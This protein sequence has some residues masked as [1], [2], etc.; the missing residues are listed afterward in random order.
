MWAWHYMWLWLQQYPNPCRLKKNMNRK[1]LLH[2][3]SC[4][5][6]LKTSICI[7]RKKNIKWCWSSCCS[8]RVWQM[9]NQQQFNEQHNPNQP[10]KIDIKPNPWYQDA[11]TGEI[12]QIES[13]QEISKACRYNNISHIDLS[14]TT[15]REI[16]KRAGMIIIT[17][18]QSLKKNQSSL[19]I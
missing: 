3:L 10:K 2:C 19:Q 9:T 4:I 8:D 1:H 13:T 18:I 12:N 14:Q 15:C 6:C 17:D 11:N 7:K 16:H 5:G